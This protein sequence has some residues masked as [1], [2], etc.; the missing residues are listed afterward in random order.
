M[1]PETMHLTLL[2]YNKDY[3]KTHV[4]TQEG[5]DLVS[6]DISKKDAKVQGIMRSLFVAPATDYTKINQKFI[7]NFENI[8]SEG[9][10]HD[11]TEI[12]ALIE[13]I[14]QLV[15]NAREFEQAKVAA[16]PTS[17]NLPVIGFTSLEKHI[18]QGEKKFQALRSL[19]EKLES[20]EATTEVKPSPSSNPE[21]ISLANAVIKSGIAKIG[22]MWEE[23]AELNV[24][25]L[26]RIPGSIGTITA[27]LKEITEGTKT[28]EEVFAE[29]KF[30]HNVT[31]M[32]RKMVRDLTPNVIPNDLEEMFL[33][34]AE[35]LKVAA[36][37]KDKDA[38]TYTLTAVEMLRK[39]VRQLPKENYELLR[40]IVKYLQILGKEEYSDYTRMDYKNLATV[41][42]LNFFSGSEDLERTLLLNIATT[43]L[44]KYADKIFYY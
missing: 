36:E 18:A 1:S 3:Y 7:R 15:R 28:A 16:Y 34:T 40:E 24:E 2:D 9:Y 39:G 10:L 38:S 4:I 22:K 6:R 30:I 26:F 21:A 5:Q 11:Q 27:H 37:D 8:F 42:S 33:L 41:W 19:L 17:A 43:N 14:G 13:K 31:G 29:E 35:T 44:I 12:S 32:M 25:G 23:N 20:S